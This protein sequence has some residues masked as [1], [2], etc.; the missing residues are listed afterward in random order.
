MN[1]LLLVVILNTSILH[2]HVLFTMKLDLDPEKSC[3]K[4]DVANLLHWS[5]TA[6]HS[7]G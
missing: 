6:A 4:F 5:M 3:D 7:E 2:K 1:K